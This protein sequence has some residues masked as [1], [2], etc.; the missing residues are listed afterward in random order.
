MSEFDTPW[1][2]Q[3]TSSFLQA[4]GRVLVPTASLTRQFNSDFYKD[5]QQE[6]FF[7]YH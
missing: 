4:A 1:D 5:I 2:G 6:I 7:S 3:N